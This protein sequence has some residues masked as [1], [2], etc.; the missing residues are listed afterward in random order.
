MPA[1]RVHNFV[2]SLDGY[3]TGEGQSTPAAF[4]HAQ[5]QFLSWFGKVNAFRELEPS[6]KLGPAEAIASAW[7]TNIGAAI[8]GR[9][10]FRPTSGPWP[11]DGWRG[12]WGEE[13]PFRTPC[14]VLTHW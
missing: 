1:L 11:D 2:V 3:S 8:M 9:N 12:W 6:G 14:F 4:G 10:K 7:G 5:Q 13:P